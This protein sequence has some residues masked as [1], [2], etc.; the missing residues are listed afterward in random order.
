M[1]GGK[2]STFKT[3]SLFTSNLWHQC[4][5]QNFEIFIPSILP[6]SILI[7]STSKWAIFILMANMAYPELH[8]SKIFVTLKEFLCRHHK[9]ELHPK[10]SFFLFQG[11][12]STI[13][14]QNRKISNENQKPREVQA[15]K[16]SRSNHSNGALS[17]YLI[18]SNHI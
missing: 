18:L 4:R 17:H 2:H 8:F 16:T 12:S 10:S 3:S 9:L 7:D 15:P 5:I 13:T 6:D 14:K 11:S 1:G